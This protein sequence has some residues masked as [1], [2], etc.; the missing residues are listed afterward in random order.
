MGELK[1][2]AD[3]SSAR[4]SVRVRTTNFSAGPYGFSGILFSC[5][6]TIKEKMATATM[7]LI[8]DEGY[9]FVLSLVEQFVWFLNLS[10]VDYYNTKEESQLLGQITEEMTKR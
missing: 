3:P 5:E 10:S 1:R 2:S 6:A 9:S 8:V 4:R 7:V